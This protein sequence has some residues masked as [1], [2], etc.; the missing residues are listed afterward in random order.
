MLIAGKFSI[1]ADSAV[2]IFRGCLR[3]GI[4]S[5]LTDICHEKPKSHTNIQLW[6]SKNEP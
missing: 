3:S 1:L 4:P 6:I 5:H 2:L